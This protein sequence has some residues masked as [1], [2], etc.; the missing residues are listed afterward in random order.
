MGLISDHGL[1]NNF[2]VQRQI[3]ADSD[4]SYRVIIKN[5][6]IALK[7]FISRPHAVRGYYSFSEVWSQ[8]CVT[9]LITLDLTW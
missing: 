5:I 8:T 9:Y 7:I 6:R 1:P 4:F 3:L 2:D